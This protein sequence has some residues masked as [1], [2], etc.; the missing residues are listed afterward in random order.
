M[1]SPY[2]RANYVDHHQTEQASIL[3]F[4]ED[5]WKVGRIGDFS[6][7]A[8]AGSLKHLFNFKQRRTIQLLLKPNGAVKKLK[9]ECTLSSSPA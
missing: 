8:G 7:D 9:G 1:I 6:F 2:A 3:R 5:N 4:I